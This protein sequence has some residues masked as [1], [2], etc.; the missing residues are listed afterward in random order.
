MLRIQNNLIN[1]N[2]L[3]KVL[4]AHWSEFIDMRTLLAFVREQFDESHQ[5]EK[6]S[7][8]RFEPCDSG[9]LL[10][11]ECKLQKLETNVNV[12]LETLIYNSGKVEIIDIS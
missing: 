12:V 3:E 7:I 2:K 1:V 10:W 5:I 9:F 11:I 8:S 4:I 6:L